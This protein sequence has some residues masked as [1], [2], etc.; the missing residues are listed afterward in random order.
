MNR[1]CVVVGIGNPYR[2][3]DR[4]G[5]VVVEMLEQEHLACQTEV[6]S[7]VGFE[8]IDTIRGYE[9]AIIVDACMLGNKPG[10]IL[11]VTVDD[12]CSPRASLHL[13]ALTLGTTLKTGY[14]C[15]PEE[16]PADIQI[17]LIEVKEINQFTQ[18]MS[19]EVEQAVREVAGRI[20]GRIAALV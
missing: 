6:L 2:Q 4:A 1:K 19:P 8:V 11:E 18:Q 13:H 14:V 9:R 3:D 10:T 5:V 12:I 7:T 15:F 16:M 17:L 20:K